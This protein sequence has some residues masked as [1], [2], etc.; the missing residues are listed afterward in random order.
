LPIDY[1]P[2]ALTLCLIISDLY[3]R[4]PASFIIIVVYCMQP[5]IPKSEL[6]LITTHSL[7]FSEAFRRFARV[8][9]GGLSASSGYTTS[10]TTQA[11]AAVCSIVPFV[12]RFK[13]DTVTLQS[14]QRTSMTT[15]YDPN[16]I[17]QAADDRLAANDW[18][19]GQRI[20]QS[21]LL[22]WTDEARESGSTEELREAMATLWLAYAQFLANAKQWKSATEA[23]EEATHCPVAGSVGRVFLDYARFAEERNKRKTAQDV[24]IRA[25]VGKGGPPAVSDEQDRELLWQEFLNMMRQSNPELTMAALKEAVEQEHQ[26]DMKADSI[27]S[28]GVETRPDQDVEAPPSKRLKMEDQEEEEQQ[29]THVVTAD[30][31]DQEAKE[32]L[33]TVQQQQL[34]PEIAAAWLVR[35]GTGPAQPPD[36]PL[37]TASPPK[38]SEPTGKDMLGVDLA[39]RVTERL[40]SPSGGLVLEV[41]RGLWT[42]QALKEMEAD[43]AVKM[44]DNTML[45]ELDRFEANLEARKLSVAGG[46]DATRN[47]VQQMNESERKNFQKTCSD[48]RQNLLSGIAREFRQLLCS[49]Q[50]LLNKLN[51]PGFEDGPTVDASALQLQH[52]ICL[53]LHSAFYISS[54]LGSEP[55]EAMLKGQLKKL[56]KEQQEGRTLSP[57]SP[58]GGYSPV[59]DRGS[60]VPLARH[61]PLPRAYGSAPVIPVQNYPYQQ[62]QPPLQ[63]VMMPPQDYGGYPLPQHPQGYPPQQLLGLPPLPT[64]Q[65]MPPY[66]GPPPPPPGQQP[67][68][69]PYYQ[70]R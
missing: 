4:L 57:V 59:P 2:C 3:P 48:Q 21:A 33:A 25:L 24:Y 39:M 23:Y 28:S 15:K 12:K 43:A 27:L 46:A 10:R 31:V 14:P 1:E 29:R 55:F 7:D 58:Q 52:Q 16:R 47:A 42:L 45:A 70:N 18:A 37:F 35:D 17:I 65:P 40:L 49:Q 62:Q 9:G 50:Q 34:P 44:V 60:P 67:P 30:T 61:S 54:K 8:E 6:V 69:P 53:V 26:G 56:Q 66:P 13:A 22:D 63:P 20:Y 64:G 19:T 36:P 41:C 32:V 11:V 5:R 38:L 68:F 51:V